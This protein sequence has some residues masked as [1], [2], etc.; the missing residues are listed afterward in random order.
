LLARAMPPKIMRTVSRR[1]PAMLAIVAAAGGALLAGCS[2]VSVPWARRQAPAPV[3]V[4]VARPVAPTPRAPMPSPPA[5]TVAVPA[6]AAPVATAPA[7]EVQPTV[8]SPLPPPIEAPSAAPA[9]GVVIDFETD[10]YRVAPA[11]RRLLETAARHLSTERVARLRLDAY[12]DPRVP[13]DYNRALAAKRAEMV[14][15]ELTELGVDPTRIDIVVHGRPVP[16]DG[17]VDVSQ[18]RR[19]ELSTVMPLAAGR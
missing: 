2:S 13:A 17:V 9:P 5:V 7:V 6:V 3:V 8:I 18:L 10:A 1:H 4:A 16:V 11:Q 14:V 12:G 19:V 15:R